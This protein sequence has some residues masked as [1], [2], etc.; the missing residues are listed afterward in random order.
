MLDHN[1]AVSIAFLRTCFDPWNVSRHSRDT[2][3]DSRFSL[4]EERA[5][6]KIR[7]L[8]LYTLK[9]EA[10]QY[11]PALKFLPLSDRSPSELA[12]S[13]ECAVQERPTW[14]VALPFCTRILWPL[15]R[16]SPSWETR[17]APIGTP[18]SSKPAFASS[19]AATNPGSESMSVF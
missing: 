8:H 2:P 4:T 10:F 9:L 5:T 18:P 14:R 15:P 17:Q 3:Q 1:V 11:F 19:T 13:L 12:F 7:T 6:W 16:I